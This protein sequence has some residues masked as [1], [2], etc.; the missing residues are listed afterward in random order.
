MIKNDEQ[1]SKAQEAIVNLQKILLEARK[2][3]SAQE[4][5]AVS[6]PILIEMQ[7][8]EQEILNYLSM[9]KAEISLSS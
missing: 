9:T 5:R 4:Y 8:R 6:E 1:L 3:H 7:Q 2:I